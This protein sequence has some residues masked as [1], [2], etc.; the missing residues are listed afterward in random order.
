MIKSSQHK[1]LKQFFRKGNQKG[2]PSFN[3]DRVKRILDAIDA[4]G[5][6]GDLMIPGFGTHQ[7]GGNRKGT[8]AITLTGNWRVTL[9]FDGRDAVDVHLEDYH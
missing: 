2:I 7:L 4:A 5:S 9:K 8:W 1:G 6:P 3:A